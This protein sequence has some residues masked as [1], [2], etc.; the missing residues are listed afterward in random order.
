M[1]SSRT[2]ASVADA[3]RRLPRGVA[4]VD[5]G[6]ELRPHRLRVTALRGLED[7]TELGERVVGVGEEHAHLLLERLR[8]RDRPYRCGLLLE[9]GQRTADAGGDRAC[10]TELRRRNL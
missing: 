10:G 2:G 1:P 3:M 4:C 6:D 5:P 7:A 8:R 9:H